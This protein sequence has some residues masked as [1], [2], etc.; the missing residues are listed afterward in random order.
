MLP[1]VRGD[2]GCC[3]VCFPPFL[4]V[5]CCLQYTPLLDRRVLPG[6]VQW[7]TS[8]RTAQHLATR[9]RIGA[10]GKAAT[11]EP[12]MVVIG[13]R[14]RCGS[15]VT[16]RPSAD[17]S[18]AGAPVN[19]AAGKSAVGRGGGGSGAADQSAFEGGV[20][21]SGAAGRSADC[22]VRGGMSERRPGRR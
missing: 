6:P 11:G 20:S 15:S 21:G 2:L 17:H 8:G 10:G 16:V 22:P 18:P 1:S 5:T 19:G 7:L 4:S 14:V 3:H 9:H 12:S 13:R